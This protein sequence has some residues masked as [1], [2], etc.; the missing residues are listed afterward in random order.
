MQHLTIIIERAETNYSAYIEGVD[1]IGV[2][3]KTIDEIKTSMAE[4]IEFYI[5]TSKEFGTEIPEAL[6]GGYD[7]TFKMD[8][9]SLLNYYDGIFGKPSLEK[10]T[11][12]NYKQLWRYAS[13]K[14][15]PRPERREKINK[16]LHNLGK[17]L[18]LV[19]V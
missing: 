13:G 19:T 12:I 18:M 14:T 17:E 1:G 4:A 7:L 11:G 15:K 6:R 16:S 3:G 8:T 5:E 9:E 10:I 2:T